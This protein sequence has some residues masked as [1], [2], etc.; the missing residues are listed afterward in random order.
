MK[1]NSFKEHS[2]RYA[3][4]DLWIISSRP[5]FTPRSAIAVLRFY[6][7][8][9]AYMCFFESLSFLLTYAFNI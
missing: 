7:S 6:L 3:K 5:D 9:C 4:E 1:L 2:S 8:V